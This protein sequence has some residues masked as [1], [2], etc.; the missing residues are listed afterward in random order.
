M[1]RILFAMIMAIPLAFNAAAQDD[2]PTDIVAADDAAEETPAVAEDADD[3]EVEDADLDE[4]SYEE[5]EDDFIPTEEIPA[6]EPI[7][8]PTNI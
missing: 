1:N 7:P 5:D 2:T 8:F 6:D 3:E 4:Q